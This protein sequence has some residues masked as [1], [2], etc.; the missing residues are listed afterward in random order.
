[1]NTAEQENITDLSYYVGRWVN[2][3]DKAR[4]ISSFTIIEKGGKIMITPENSKMGFYNEEWDS[5]ELKPHAYGPDMD[6]IVAFQ[7][8]FNMKDMNV[9]LAV[10][11]NKG[12]LVIA[13]Y[14]SFKETDN[15]SDCFV[16]EFFYKI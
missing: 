1:M 2:S 16:R 15:R 5:S 3:Y 14:F 7:A 11:E 12:L 8:H 9:F 6:D 13:A 4:V 10:N